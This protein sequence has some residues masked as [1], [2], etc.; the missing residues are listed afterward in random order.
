M[1]WL[2]P[3]WAVVATPAAD[4]LAASRGGIALLLILLTLSAV[5]VAAPTWNPW[6]LPWLQQWL[7]HLGW[8]VSG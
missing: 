7:T 6:T 5:S 3:L 8:L 1:F 2:A 4:R